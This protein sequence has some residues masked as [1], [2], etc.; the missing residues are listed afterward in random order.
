MND[1]EFDELA[2]GHALG[3][4]SPEDEARYRAALAE[5]GT[6]REELAASYAETSA[7]LAELADEVPP[8]P[9][10]RDDLLRRIA[11]EAAVAE[12]ERPA[13]EPVVDDAHPPVAGEGG[14]ESGRTH[15]KARQR[16]FVLAA[17][18]A[19]LLAVG[20]GVGIGAQLSRPESV[21]A[22]ERIESA[23]DAQ[24]ADGALPSGSTAT[25]H[26]SAEAGEAVLV[27][28]GLPALA[29]DQAYELWVVN[30]TGA[31]SA[32]VI[33]GGGDVVALVDGS[34]SAG[35]V[36]ALT[37]EAA[38]GSPTGQPTTDPLVAIPMS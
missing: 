16:W 28:D 11:A 34:V 23:S 31:V 24:A 17:S 19:A 2:A 6:G 8:P 32:G 36:V 18:V 26:W 38:G 3:A 9:G 13:E 22:L 37:V 12:G 30:D 20:A 21:V 35:D 1:E 14:A 27:F 7:H 33:D 29:S 25:L 4:L 10:I 15:P 5:P